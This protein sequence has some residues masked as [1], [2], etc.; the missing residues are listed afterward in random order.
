MN[1][2]QFQIIYPSYIDSTK[3]IQ[4]GRRIGKEVAVP[5]PNV[6]DLSLALQRLQI[7]H[8]LQPYK[9]YSRDIQTLWDNPGRVKVDPQQYKLRYATKRELL[10]EMARIITTL[11]ERQQRLLEEEQQLLL[12]Q[13]EQ[14]KEQKSNS[15]T[16]VSA[17]ARS[18][19]QSSSSSSNN[20]NNKKTGKKKR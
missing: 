1:P 13:Q 11:P 3:S 17:A 7:R 6:S 12:Q 16:A 19:Q 18:A 9:G 8:V 20:N 10:Q 5:S 14:D 4:Q 15:S 2:S